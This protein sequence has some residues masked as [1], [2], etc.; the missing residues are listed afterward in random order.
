[1]RLCSRNNDWWTFSKTEC[2]WCMQ[3][4]RYVCG[5][6]YVFSLFVSQKQKQSFRFVYNDY[7]LFDLWKLTPATRSK[8]LSFV[9]WFTSHTLKQILIFP[10]TTTKMRINGFNFRSQH[11]L[12]PTITT[13]T[14]KIHLVV[15]LKHYICRNKKKKNHNR[16]Y[17]CYW[18]KNAFCA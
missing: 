6:L 2:K 14:S 5:L 10:R 12:F 17:K 16:I 18:K 1:M 15:W 3:W 13:T 9:W 7:W 8:S 11:F 4:R